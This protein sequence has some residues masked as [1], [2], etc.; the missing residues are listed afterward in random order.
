MDNADTDYAPSMG[1]VQLAGQVTAA[2]ALHA[3]LCRA[4][5]ADEAAVNATLA[6]YYAGLEVLAATPATTLAGL[7]AKARALATCF[8]GGTIEGDRGLAWSLV[9]DL[10][11]HP[12]G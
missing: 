8:I 1:V 6:S 5:P 7:Q 9:T 11:Q 10:M 4:M 3:R 12:A 2:D